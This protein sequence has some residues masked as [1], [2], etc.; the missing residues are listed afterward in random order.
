MLDYPLRMCGVPL[1]RFRYVINIRVY[2][3]QD[4]FKHHLTIYYYTTLSISL[5]GTHADKSV[6]E[7]KPIGASDNWIIA[8]NYHN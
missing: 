8:C 1:V 6:H 4:L 2:S 7:Y 3:T 5:S